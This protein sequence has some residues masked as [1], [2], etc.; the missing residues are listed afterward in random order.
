MA[1][2]LAGMCANFGASEATMIKFG[3]SGWRAIM[4]EEFTFQNVRTVVQA[5]ANC[6]HRKFPDKKLA[7][8]VNYD[9]R[10]LSERF[11]LEAAKVLSHNQI[12]VF[13]SDRDA[14][15]QAQAY[16]IILRGAHAGINFTASF[17]PPEYNGLKYNVETGAPALPV[18][19]DSIE[20][21]IKK[22]MQ[23]SSFCPYYPK[24]EFIERIDLQADYLQYIQDRIDFELIKNAGI[25]VG[26]DLLFSAS[27]EYLD[28]ILE[29]NQIVFE[30][31]HGY[32][33]PYFGG[34]TPSC[35]EE[36]LGELKTLVT[37]K[38]L[39]LGVATDAD[40]DRFGIVDEQG[41]F[42]EQNLILALLLDYC[43]TVKQW[44]GG[45]A[46]SI[47]TTHMIDRI[48]RVH[49]LPLFK[50]PVGFKYIADL[51]LKKQIIFGGEESACLAVKDH[52]PEKDGIFAGLM[53]LEMLAAR[54]QSLSAQ[55]ED[56]FRR[57]G[58]LE[59]SQ[60]D[61]TL[62]SE[63]ER[64]LKQLIRKPPR[65]LAGLTV[66]NAETIDGLKLDFEDDAW[67]LLRFSGTV[68]VIRC[69]GEA[70]TVKEL[71]RLMSA[72]VELVF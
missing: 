40:G 71:E 30:E 42:V 12:H 27:R 50:T 1:L 13:L 9:T 65:E 70:G 22:L 15:S 16:Q 29:E 35:T 26:V 36:N 14:P 32:V 39:Q 3:T 52:L 4:G 56:L 6:L 45:V 8:V 33:D 62:N 38:D 59:G 69:Y 66:V 60:R 49:D 48:A 47:A 43:V 64:K 28:E 23:T 51:F 54:G 58:Q 21:E 63:R 20:E 61:I 10:F 5:I 46:R 41:R 67:I 11:A 55:L 34:Y 68:P 53:V 7:V 18:E 37:E 2:L 72:G 24:S 44:K 57:Y 19:T 17:N 31:I 25:K